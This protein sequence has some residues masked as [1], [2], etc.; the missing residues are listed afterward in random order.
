MKTITTY[1]DYGYFFVEYTVVLREPMPAS[2]DIMRR[3][4]R[5]RTLPKGWRRRG[6]V[7]V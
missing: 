7:V 5:D 2:P 3:K 1:F 4:R 6:D